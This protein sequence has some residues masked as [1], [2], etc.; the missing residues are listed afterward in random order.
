MKKFIIN[1]LLIIGIPFVII[2][3][4]YWITD[5]FKINNPFS[6]E[7]FSTVNREYISIELFLLQNP[8]YNYN[9]FIFGSSRASGINTYT[10][11]YLLEN[12]TNQK[13]TVSQYL[14]QAWSETL[15]G[16]NQKIEFLDRNN[17]P[18]NNALVLVDIDIIG[19]TFHNDQ[20]PQ[21][22]LKIKHYALSGQSKMLYQKAFIK[23][24]MGSPSQIAVSIKQL[25]K[26]KPMYEFDTVSNEWTVDN[27]YNFMQVPT[28]DSTLN[29]DDFGDRPA[30]EQFSEQKITTEYFNMLKNIKNIFD[31]HQ[32]N[33]KII[34]TPTYNQIHINKEDL[35]ILEHL[36]GADNVFNFSGKNYITEDKYNF[37]DI[38][39]FDVIV[40]WWLLHEIYDI[41]NAI[42]TLEINSL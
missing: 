9:S 31:K 3:A 11:K 21:E 1:I 42:D 5:P 35:K 4:L 23:A 6:L 7:N 22:T 16:I 30:E 18:I 29:K 10:W 39:H 33:Y 13:D 34:V 24:Y 15:T 28:R 38:N 36:F 37:M 8:K 17:I 12:N 25:I 19:T 27:I 32:T 26:P 40:G 2:F 20:E 41:S 14:F